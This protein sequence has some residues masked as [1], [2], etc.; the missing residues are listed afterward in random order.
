MVHGCVEYTECC[1]EME[2]VSHGISYVTT[3]QHHNPLLDTQNALCK[4]TAIHLE[5]H[6]TTV[7]WVCSVEEKSYSCHCEILGTQSETEQGLE[8]PCRINTQGT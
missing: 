5:P 8:H 3:K 6:T 2:A 1:A 7:Q 4:D